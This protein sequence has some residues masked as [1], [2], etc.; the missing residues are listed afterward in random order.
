GPSVERARRACRRDPAGHR[1][2][3][4]T[5]YSYKGGVGR[6]LALAHL[7]YEFARRGLRVLAVDFDLEAP[8]LERYCFEGDDVR[9]AREH[10]GIVD[11][12]QEYRIAL[13]DAKHFEARSFQNWPRFTMPVRDPVNSA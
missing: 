13:T 7:A 12:I 11:L 6:S 5:L 4:F 9:R 3:I 2:V 1:R 8:G 10:P